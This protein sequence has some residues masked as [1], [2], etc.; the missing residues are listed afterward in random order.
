M[1]NKNKWEYIYKICILYIYKIH[2]YL[3]V[4]YQCFEVSLQRKWGLFICLFVFN[5]FLLL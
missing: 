1:F 4:Q 5:V 2:K 3:S